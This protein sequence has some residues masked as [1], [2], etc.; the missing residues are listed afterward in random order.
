MT[1]HRAF[2][3]DQKFQIVME[4]LQ[5]GA[6]VAEICRRHQISS[7]LYYL[8]RERALASMKASLRS[9]EGT[10]ELS[11]KLENARLKKLLADV[12]I[13]NDVLREFLEGKGKNSGGRS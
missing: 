11:L 12:T 10:P 13:A 2:S 8:W 3:A 9:K 1:T 4:G 7:T 6:N 5:P